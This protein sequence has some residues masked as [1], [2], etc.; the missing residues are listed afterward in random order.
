MSSNGEA[1]LA[2]EEENFVPISRSLA[3]VS[4]LGKDRTRINEGVLD[5]GRAI[6]AS[7]GAALD[8]TNVS[9]ASNGI[10]IG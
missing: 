5:S 4:R 2:F 7:N 8:G 3:R 10:A 6:P 9:K 1:T